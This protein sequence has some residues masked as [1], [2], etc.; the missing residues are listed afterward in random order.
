[1][2]DKF[3]R[4]LYPLVTVL[5]IV[6]SMGTALGCG[7]SQSDNVSKNLGKKCEAFKCQ[8]RIIA[9]NGITDKVLLDV[10]GRCSI[11]KN[12]A[13]QGSG[14]SEVLELTCKQGPHEY[15]KHFVGLSDNVTWTSTQ[16]QPLDASEFRTKFILRPQALAP[17]IDLVQ[18]NG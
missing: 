18:P 11:E 17:D 4:T 5:L 12:D 7:K 16:L 13:L 3:S 2:N 1:M 14:K 6:I 9:V 15:R 8:R 10:E